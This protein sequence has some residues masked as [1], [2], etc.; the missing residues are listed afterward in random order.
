MLRDAFAQKCIKHLSQFLYIKYLSQLQ[1][2]FTAIFYIKYLSQHVPVMKILNAS[3]NSTCLVK[4]AG[5]G[6]A[7]TS[8]VPV[9]S[10]SSGIGSK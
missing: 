7:R 3:V 10:L 4:L 9:R 5:G 8:V 1:K 6:R 2:L